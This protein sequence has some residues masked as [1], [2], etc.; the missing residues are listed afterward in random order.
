MTY[1]EVY[2]EACQ[3]SKMGHFVNDW[4]DSKKTSDKTTLITSAQLALHCIQAFTASFL[5]K[6]SEI[7][8][9]VHTDD[10]TCYY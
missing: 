7:W 2:P 6:F 8:N 5:Q 9:L 3:I 4:Q 1:T 10:L